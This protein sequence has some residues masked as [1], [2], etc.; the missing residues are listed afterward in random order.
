LCFLI[1]IYTAG[2]VKPNMDTFIV[3]K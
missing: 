2:M 3:D 1:V